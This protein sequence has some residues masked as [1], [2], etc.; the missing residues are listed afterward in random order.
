MAKG[1]STPTAVRPQIEQTI[2]DKFG[3]FSTE[4]LDLAKEQFQVSQDR[5]SELDQ[6]TQSVIQN[7][8]NLGTATVDQT[9]QLTEYNRRIADRIAGQGEDFSRRGQE[10]LDRY[11]RDFVPLEQDIVGFARDY[12]TPERR[13][14]AAARAKADVQ[15]ASDQQRQTAQRRASAMGVRPGSGRYTG[16]ERAGELATTVASVDAQNRARDDVENKGVALRADA[17]NL[18]RSLSGMGQNLAGMGINAGTTAAGIGSTNQQLQ[19][20]ASQIAMNAGSNALGAQQ[21]ANQL[22]GLN[23]QNLMTGYQGAGQFLGDQANT[24]LAA[25]QSDLAA[26]QMQNNQ[27]NQ[28]NSGLWSAIGTGVGWLLS[29]E[30]VKEDKQEIP[31]GEALEM[32]DEMRV[33][34]WKY[35]DGVADE[36]EHI[37]TYAQDFNEA[38]GAGSS[39][40]IP[41][42]DAI[43]VTMKAVQD[44]NNKVDALVTG[45]SRKGRIV[46]STTHEKRRKQA[47]K[48]NMGNVEFSPTGTMAA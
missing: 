29:D 9:N 3:E 1:A 38:T 12:D 25:Q 17:A 16:V 43:G 4:Y 46:K 30:N 41:I 2:A 28:N 34:K 40:G 26:A 39:E 7:N 18:G 31:D 21:Q 45:T 14:E 11:E 44:L 5:Q 23:Y 24:I 10:A 36:G 27:N 42:Q 22:A 47:E 35:K 32:I 6:L 8:L 15:T 48:N 19:N 33:E 20:T 13:A 37:G